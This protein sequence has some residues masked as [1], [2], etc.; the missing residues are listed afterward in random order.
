MPSHRLCVFLDVGPLLY[1]SQFAPT[2]F[3][4]QFS[5]IIILLS[6]KYLEIIM[7]RFIYVVFFNL[8]RAPFMLTK[9]RYQAAHP[10]KYSQE[11][12]YSL[13]KHCIRL[14]KLTGGIS[15][16]AYGTENLPKEGGYML[17][18]NHQGK[19][20]VFGIIHT[21]A[22]PCSVVMD[23]KK[24][25]TIFVR[26]AIDL[27][28]GKRLEIDNVRQALTIINEVAEDVAKGSRYILFPE[29]G[30]EFNNKNTVCNFKAG[31]FKISLK[32]KTP[33]VPV[34]LVDSYRVFNSFWWGPV[35]TQ[36]H[37]LEPIYYEEYG[38]LKTQEIATMVQERITQ[39]INDVLATAP[40]S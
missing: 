26:E 28:K 15:T 9:M 5:C 2:L 21:H 34:A 40:H 11:E 10:E 36:V 35:K 3:F 38:H 12:R 17:Y 30:Y 37:Y 18:P 16:K 25:Y 20:D 1:Q 4:R 8:F 39:K 27:L 33:I 22:K 14:M 19:Y 24:S 6:K 29:G 23:K 31:C 7:I 13:A 32:T